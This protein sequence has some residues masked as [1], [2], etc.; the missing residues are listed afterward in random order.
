VRFARREITSGATDGEE[1]TRFALEWRSP[2]L[3]TPRT[4]WEGGKV[5]RVTRFVVSGLVESVR[6]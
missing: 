5:I 1:R 4:T 3:T 6:R 2:Q